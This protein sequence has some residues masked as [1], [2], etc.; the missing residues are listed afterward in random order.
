VEK[1]LDGESASFEANSVEAAAAAV[2]EL[3]A[4]GFGAEQV[5]EGRAA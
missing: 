2:E 5:R 4:C 3:H 1:A